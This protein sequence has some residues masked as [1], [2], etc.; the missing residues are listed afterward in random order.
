MGIRV[1]V[2]RRK[3]SRWKITGKL[4]KRAKAGYIVTNVTK[5]VLPVK[6]AIRLSK[7]KNSLADSTMNKIDNISLRT[8]KQIGLYYPTFRR[9]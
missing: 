2:Q 8:A 5:R 6:K 4:A 1:M 9:S 3:S 7:I